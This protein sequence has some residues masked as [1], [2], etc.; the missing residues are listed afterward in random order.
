[1]ILSQ[2]LESKGI[3]T[4]FHNFRKIQTSNIAFQRGQRRLSGGIRVVQQKLQQKTKSRCFL[5]R[6]KFKV[7]KASIREENEIDENETS[8][9]S[10]LDPA[11]DLRPDSTLKLALTIPTVGVLASLVFLKLHIIQDPVTTFW[12]NTMAN[13]GIMIKP[14]D[15]HP[16]NMAI[17]VTAMGGY[18]TYLGFRI[19]QGY[20]GEGTVGISDDTAAQLHPKMM[21]GMG[22]FFFF[23]AFG[24]ITGTLHEGLD[25]FNS[26]HAVTGFAGLSVLFLQGVLGVVMKDDEQRRKLHTY[27]GST[28]MA[29]F[30]LHASLGVYFFIWLGSNGASGY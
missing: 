9:P 7:T 6:L 30:L 12:T 26:P 24:G 1:M 2:S 15:F 13:S 23:G 8:T 25:I 10:S 14:R 3:S 11:I 28:L 20:G 18:G 4:S 22:L 21:L 27:L 17:V 29:L 16:F 19:R 5:L